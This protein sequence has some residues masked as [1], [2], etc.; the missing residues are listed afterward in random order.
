MKR[1][2]KGL[3]K[4][5]DRPKMGKTPLYVYLKPSERQLLDEIAER[6]GKSVQAMVHGM[7]MDYMSM[8]S[9]HGKK[10]EEKQE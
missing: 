7:I 8:F 10:W 5:L 6:Y 1:F 3:R 2:L 4:R 9:E